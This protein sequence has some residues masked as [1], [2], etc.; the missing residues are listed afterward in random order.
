MSYQ[1]LDEILRNKLD[2]LHQKKLDEK[3]PEIYAKTVLNALP[4]TEIMPSNAAIKYIKQNSPLDDENTIIRGINTCL[5]SKDLI[6]INRG[7]KLWLRKNNLK[8]I[9]D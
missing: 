4:D 9:V 7:G 3:M 5:D 6:S 8:G 2:R 1:P